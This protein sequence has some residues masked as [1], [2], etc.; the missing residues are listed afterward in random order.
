VSF[1]C[2]RAGF[3]LL[4]QSKVPDIAVSK[5]VSPATGVIG[6]LFTYTINL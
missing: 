1:A 4:P 5:A 3:V 6:T 2:L